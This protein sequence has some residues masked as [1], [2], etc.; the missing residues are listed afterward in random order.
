MNLLSDGCPAK[1]KRHVPI[2]SGFPLSGLLK[3]PGIM[4]RREYFEGVSA[5]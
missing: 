5:A 1:G 3:T 4:L 2:Q